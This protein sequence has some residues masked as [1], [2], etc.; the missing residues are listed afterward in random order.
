[1]DE[2]TYNL[3]ANFIVV[4]GYIFLITRQWLEIRRL[5][6]EISIIRWMI[7]SL[8]FLALLVLIPV[9]V[10]Q[11]LKYLGM[12]SDFLTQLALI[13]SPTNRILTLV[14]LIGISTIK[15]TERK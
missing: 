8:Y 7:F 11:V 3:I 12:P 2:I 13:L 15:I 5:P 4:V 9:T 10:N 6:D 1:M 14:V